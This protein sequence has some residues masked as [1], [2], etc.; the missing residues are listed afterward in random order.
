MDVTAFDQI[1]QCRLLVKIQSAIHLIKPLYIGDGS[2]FFCIE[3]P[4]AFHI[5]ATL[6]QETGSR[7]FAKMRFDQLFR[8]CIGYEFQLLQK[9]PLG[10]R[11]SNMPF[12]REIAENGTLQV[13][14]LRLGEQIGFLKLWKRFI[15]R[16]RPPGIYSRRKGVLW[17]FLML[18]DVCFRVFARKDEIILPVNFR[19]FAGL[20]QCLDLCPQFRCD[21]I[22]RPFL[23][24]LAVLSVDFK[25]FLRTVIECQFQ[26]GKLLFI[27]RSSGNLRRPAD[28]FLR[29]Q[30]LLI[31]DRLARSKIG[32][33]FFG[34]RNQRTMELFLVR[35]PFRDVS[36][37]N[38]RTGKF[39]AFR[40]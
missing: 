12:R 40:K 19:S 38:I 34:Q 21:L 5:G 37:R 13:I 14:G 9:L 30:D 33:V 26:S 20:L 32:Q 8:L 35:L 23:S 16:N 3:N 22:Q 25:A 39:T 1:F 27:D 11:R 28:Q 7:G 29:K 10:F 2:D 4:A 15:L 18:P 24:F 6:V 17:I 31:A 36:N